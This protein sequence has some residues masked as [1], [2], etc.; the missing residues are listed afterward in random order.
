MR[1]LLVH[2][3]LVDLGGAEK[4][5]E[6][7]IESLSPQ[8]IFTLFYDEKNFKASPISKQDIV[9]SFLD[10][11]FFKKRYRTFL[12]LFPYAIE[13]FDTDGF[14]LIF[15]SS[16]CVAKGI[17]PKVDQIHICYCHTPMRYIWDL[18]FEYLKLSKLD[19]GLKSVLAKAFFHYLRI[20]DESSSS[21]VDYFISNSNFVGKR[22][23]K[24]YKRKAKTIYP[25]CDVEPLKEVVKKDG[26]FLFASRLVSYKRADIVIEAFKEL[27]LP[28]KVI[29]DGPEY[30][31]LKRASSEN[32]KFLGFLKKDDLR[33]EIASSMALIFPPIEDF[34]ILPVEAQSLGT[35][36]IA[37][38]MGGSLETVIPPTS[39]NFEDATGIFFENQD[40]DSLINAVLE[41]IK[42]SNKFKSESLLKNASRFSKER[43]LR[44][45]KEFV[46]KIVKEK[47]EGPF[48]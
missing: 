14:D 27:K 2:D 10:K 15:S 32:I 3:W 12:P 5:V 18:T 48:C 40:K 7:L 11:P 41:F 36:V 25:P 34:G 1:T 23:E 47:N 46:E 39:N 20:W 42:N 13:D 22:I 44:E 45:I 30:K 43:F 8:K 35:P 16:H 19:K 24:F 21:R 31:E 4:V 38:K 37:F 33:K 28:L 17:I 29:G 6:S 9:T 26:S